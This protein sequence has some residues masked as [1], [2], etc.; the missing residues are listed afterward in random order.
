[1]SKFKTGIQGK[2]PVITEPVAP[3]APLTIPETVDE[4]LKV[5][6][7]ESKPTT[8]KEIS[9]L[10]SYVNSVMNATYVELENFDSKNFSKTLSVIERS[11][12]NYN[13]KEVYFAN[14]LFI[15]LR[16]VSLLISKLGVGNIR[17]TGQIWP[18]KQIFWP[19]KC[20]LTKN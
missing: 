17:P 1:M 10:A 4:I 2:G 7:N 3:P 9:K 8:K 13:F 16:I 14:L 20:F 6:S 18:A 12:E 19:A 5:F 11:I 15:K